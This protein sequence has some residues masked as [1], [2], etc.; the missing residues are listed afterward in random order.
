[1]T[2]SL[3]LDAEAL[4]AELLAGVRGLLRP[5]AVL[6]GLAGKPTI[7]FVKAVRQARKGL[8]DVACPVEAAVPER[9]GRHGQHGGVAVDAQ[10]L[11]WRSAKEEASARLVPAETPG[12][13]PT[14]R[15]S[16]PRQSL[17]APPTPVQLLARG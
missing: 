12:L 14:S 16:H 11:L 17:P 1:M 6:V 15:E 2:Q 13:L 4:Y 5:E 7:A 3:Q 9:P 10:A 8:V